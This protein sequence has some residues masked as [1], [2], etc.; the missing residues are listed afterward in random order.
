[1]T[2]Q[3]VCKYT[4]LCVDKT[5]CHLSYTRTVQLYCGILILI[6]KWIQNTI[7]LSVVPHMCKVR[8]ISAE[9]SQKTCLRTCVVFKECILLCVST[10]YEFRFSCQTQKYTKN[11]LTFH[12]AYLSLLVAHCHYMFR[13]M[14]PSSG[15]KL[16]NLTLLNY[17][18][19]TIM[20]LIM[21]MI[22]TIYE[23]I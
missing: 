23:S 12:S 1:V 6:Q 14:E 17:T 15:D 2:S 10:I 13:L 4:K 16:T 19:Y 3:W 18:S 11:S 22:S 9:G 20:I 21:I 8:I 5:V 7:T